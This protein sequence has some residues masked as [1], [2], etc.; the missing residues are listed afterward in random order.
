[1]EANANVSTLFLTKS[2]EAINELINE[3]PERCERKWLKHDE[4]FQALSR[5]DY[6]ILVRNQNITNEV[7]SPV[8]FAEYLNAGLKVLIS[9]NLGDFTEFVVNN[10]CGVVVTTQIGS[11]VPVTS[12]ESERLKK[13][14]NN[15]FYKNS[16]TISLAYSKMLNE[17]ETIE[18]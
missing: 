14:A 8:K 18:K 12:I 13:L 9:E 16:E 11:L 10:N 2:N 1:M 6:G 3:F 17:L 7:A 15:F 5:C 4:V